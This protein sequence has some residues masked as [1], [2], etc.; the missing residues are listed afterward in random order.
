MPRDGVVVG[1]RGGPGTAWRRARGHA[2]A[3]AVLALL[4]N[5]GSV[6]AQ[7]QEP[8]RITGE[9]RAEATNQPLIGVQV[10]LEGTGYGAVTNNIGRY[11]IL[12]VPAGSYT[13]RVELI[14]YGTVTRSIT[15]APGQAL[16]VDVTLRQRA[17]ELESL[18]VTGTAG[19]ARRRE[20]GTSVAQID[21]ADFATAAVQTA[22][23]VL[24]ARAPGVTVIDDTGLVGGDSSIRLR[25]DNTYW[26]NSPLIYVD[27]VRIETDHPGDGEIDGE[28]P[29]G[30]GDIAPEDIARIEIIKGAAATTLYGTE[31]ASGVIQIFTKRGASGAPAWSFSVEQGINHMGHV[32]P[33]MDPTGLN[34]NDCTKQ[35][36]P[37]PSCPASGSWLRDGHRQEY[38]LSVRG[39]SE[40]V[41][42]YVSGKWGRNEGVIDPQHMSD[43]GLRANFGF[44][45]TNNLNIS[46]NSA[47][48]NRRIRWIPDGDNADGFLLNVFRGPKGYTPDNR[49][50]Q[51]ME[52]KLWQGVDHFLTSTS[53][54]WTPL[55]GMTHRFTA[56]IDWTANDIED[57]KPWGFFS[58]PEG[59][60]QNVQSHNRMYTLDYAG[61][62]EADLGELVPAATFLSGVT[63]S[64]S[65]GMQAYSEYEWS[66]NATGQDF[67]GPGLK[68]VGSGARTDASEGREGIASGG[69]F[70]QE[71]IGINDRLFITAGARWDGFSTFGEG[72][73]LAMYPKF[74]ASYILSDHDFWPDWWEVMKLRAAVGEA[75]RAPGA[76]AAER[77]WSPVSHEGEPAVILNDLGNPEL[78]PER[79]REIEGG[80]EASLLDGRIGLEFTY[81]TH[82]TYDGLINITPPPSIGTEQAVLRNAGEFSNRGVEAL[83]NLSVVRRENV[84]WDFG[85]HYATN[86][87]KV[88]DIAGLEG[89][90][91]EIGQPVSAYFGIVVQNPDELGAEPV[92]ELQYLGPTFPT[93]D[94]GVRTS[95]TLFRRL[96]VAVLGEGQGGHVKSASFARAQTQREVWPPCYA[97]QEKIA[98]GQTAD[99]TAWERARCDPN[100]TTSGMWVEPADFFK[101]R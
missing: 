67:A 95:L 89:T 77:I 5:L 19:A 28:G 79:T 18:V 46:I 65:W 83:V 20:L 48:T 53:V 36:P 34:L 14:G 55:E 2:V 72:F 4:V 57:E 61:T 98:A 101:L 58:D 25:G 1:A 73:G 76:F 7:A 44:R 10:S 71:R 80:F 29:S 3:A 81:F 8:G 54:V 84:L 12:D 62:W 38:D 30:I 35:D 24:Q 87:S 45:P 51:I 43:W 15:V 64:L 63:S 23:D 11:L 100:I 70:V 9:V 21:A 88:V 60:R 74:S 31:A 50:G 69:F 26:S 56:G 17:I 99:L 82:R 96:S 32:G 85:F 66:L 41:T 90:L 97:I 94:Y 27:G 6:E 37:D 16:N 93:R 59:Q 22:E 91:L 47:Y 92:M 78:G 86:S 42:Y 13:L 39:G 52:M 33:E 49:D 75:G 40:E 68:L